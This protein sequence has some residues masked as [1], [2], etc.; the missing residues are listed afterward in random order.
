[1]TPAK[2]EK[3]VIVLLIAIAI[4]FIFLRFIHLKADFPS[5]IT[6]S[7][8]LYTDEGW[9]SSGAISYVL[10][11]NWYRKGDFNPAINMPLFHL[12]QFVVFSL[13]GKSL[14]SARITGVFFFILLTI[15]ATLLAYRYV[16]KKGA[17]FTAFFLSI[18][19]IL[20]SYSR[21][22]LLEITMVSFVLLSLFTVSSFRG[23]NDFLVITVSSLILFLA[24]LVKATAFFAI[25]LLIYI[26]L[27][28][29]ERWR[30]KFLFT[31]TIL[32]SF[33]IST[34]FYNIYVRSIYPEDFSYFKTI[35]VDERMLTDGFS[36]CKN[37][38]QSLLA[39]RLIEPFI[40]II[41]MIICFIAFLSSE[42][43]RRNKIVILSLLWI[44]SYSGVLAFSK[45]HPPRYFLPLAVPIAFLF[46]IVISFIW[47][48]SSRKYAIFVSLLVV[49]YLLFFDGYKIVKYITN[50]H[51]SFFNM[52]KEI[53]KIVLKEN[54]SDER[55]ILMG[56]FADSIAL[57]ANVYP[58]NAKVGTKQL[59]WKIRKYSPQYFVSLGK[60]ASTLGLLS[61]SCKVKK[62]GEWNVFDNY[63]FGRKV[64][65]YRLSK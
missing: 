7:S 8:A 4:F 55:M 22:S 12:I 13:L 24:Q 43:F 23:S 25:P 58:I 27:M 3:F 20:F 29:S 47:R 63:Y 34:V 5:S 56:D 31:L 19:Y 60:D 26:S 46:G 9:Y 32:S 61:K 42:E 38:Y 14:F 16:D 30:K 41:V 1:M 21:L 59:N 51:Y 15:L 64:L 48:K 65:L 44:A 37:F 52:S 62:I 17:F 40:Y 50:P 11:G 39:G 36:V 54:S 2:I 18:N 35:N 10:S 53:N 33:F 57:T 28:R 6:W 49:V 45:Y